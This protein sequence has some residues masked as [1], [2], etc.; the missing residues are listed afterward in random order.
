MTES[1][2]DPEADGRGLPDAPG[3]PPW[4][5]PTAPSGF[6]GAGLAGPAVPPPPAPPRPTAPRPLPKRSK[7]PIVA[8]VVLLLVIAGIV[9][10]IAKGGKDDDPRV[11]SR[12]PEATVEAFSE[13][14][15]TGDADTF[16][17]L[18]SDSQRENLSTAFGGRCI[19][20]VGMILALASS[21]DAVHLEVTGSTIDG[22][23]ATV[24]VTSDGHAG[25]IPLV[26]EHGRWVIDTAPDSLVSGSVS[27]GDD[28]ADGS[29]GS[30]GSVGSDVA[31]AG[32]AAELQ[33]V[34]TAVEAYFAVNGE[35]PADAQALVDEG[36]LRELPTGSSVGPDGTVTA[37]G[38]CA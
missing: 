25:E 30:D 3:P 21:M 23:R 13:A 34:Q 24:A 11:T 20:S 36:F 1:N 16:C 15:A 37:A 28:G 22:D 5:S 9:A 17:Q 14:I 7:L 31:P 19:D 27:S 2:D 33:T 18:L 29:D 35:Y 38:D 8:A 32:C 26:K 6:T 4:A 10:V 12:S